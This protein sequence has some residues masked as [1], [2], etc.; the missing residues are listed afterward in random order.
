[1]DKHWSSF[2]S[3]CSKIAAMTGLQDKKNPNNRFC[4]YPQSMALS[5]P[6]AWQ[7]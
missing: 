4:F 6:E 3:L 2:F 5:L 1:M 7:G